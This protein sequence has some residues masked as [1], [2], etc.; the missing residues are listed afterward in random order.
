MLVSADFVLVNRRSLRP[1]ARRAKHV[2]GMAVAANLVAVV[3]GQ[4]V[5][6]SRSLGEGTTVVRVAGVQ[7]FFAGDE[8]W[9]SEESTSNNCEDY[10]SNVFC[11]RGLKH[12]SESAEN[13]LYCLYLFK[14]GRPSPPT[15]ALLKTWAPW[16]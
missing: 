8:R 12:R 4:V 2:S 1:V 5:L 11:L 6:L 16:L 3:G 15:R 10:V 14:S 9:I 13:V 7:R